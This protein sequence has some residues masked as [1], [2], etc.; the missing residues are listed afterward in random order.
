MGSTFSIRAGA[1]YGDE[2]GA[3]DTQAVKRV[4]LAAQLVAQEFEGG[5][6]ALALALQVSPNTLQHKV[7]PASERHI[8]GLAEAVRMELMS[9]NAAVL[10]A[11]ALAL[12]FTCVRAVPDQSGGDPVE[13]FMRVQQEWG[14]FTS[15]AADGLLG[16]S[17]TPNQLKRLEYHTNELFA[18]VGHLVATVAARVPKRG[19]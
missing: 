9:G 11:H 14:E 7:N 12:G 5:V 13:A 16:Q 18:A 17:T 4:L 19:A 2:P 6:P 10:H 8:L 15:S 3:G 1:D